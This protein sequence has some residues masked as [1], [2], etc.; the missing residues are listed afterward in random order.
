M[1]R[2]IAQSRRNFCRRNCKLWRNGRCTAG[3]WP[4]WG[5]RRPVKGG[6]YF[7]GWLEC[8]RGEKLEERRW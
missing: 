7:V 1:L 4:V 2:A 8:E 3:G 5:P 6:M